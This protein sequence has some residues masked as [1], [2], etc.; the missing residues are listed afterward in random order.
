MASWRRFNNFPLWS[1]IL[2]RYL[3]MM[4]LSASFFWMTEFGLLLIFSWTHHFT[5]TFT[6]MILSCS[7][8]Q[9]VLLSRDAA[10][11]RLLTDCYDFTA[12]FIFFSLLINVGYTLVRFSLFIFDLCI[13]CTLIFDLFV[14]CIICCIF[15]LSER[16]P[17]RLLLFWVK[18]SGV[19][20]ACVDP[21]DQ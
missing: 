20:R 8:L 9:H 6:V 15:C 16:S 11:L 13:A 7:F 3:F 10:P 12:R 4:S 17:L 19:I 14:F 1:Y 21:R 5:F 2:F 18:F